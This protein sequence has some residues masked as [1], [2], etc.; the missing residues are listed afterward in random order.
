MLLREGR[1][2]PTL[3]SY[4]ATFDHGVMETVAESDSSS[5]TPIE[6]DT[7]H[8]VMRRRTQSYCLDPYTPSPDCRRRPRRYSESS[9][10]M[11]PFEPSSTVAN[12]APTVDRM[13]GGMHLDVERE[14]CEI[15]LCLTTFL[16][17]FVT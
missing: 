5:S 2:L 12:C 6:D 10:Q 8:Q 4:I 16:D 1:H 7:D 9:V 13:F 14:N 11:I 17:E 15:D 3:A